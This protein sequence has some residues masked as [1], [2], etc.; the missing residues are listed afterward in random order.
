M[1]KSLPPA[2]GDFVWE[3][4]VPLILVRPPRRPKAGTPPWEAPEGD[5]VVV[6]DPAT[7]VS[8]LL[9]LRQIGL[10]LS[11]GCVTEKAKVKDPTRP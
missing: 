10:V 9:G 1:H 5:P 8:F 2:K 3:A 7:D 4:L 6:I 11:V